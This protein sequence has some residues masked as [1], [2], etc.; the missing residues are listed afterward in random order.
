MRYIAL[1][2]LLSASLFFVSCIPVKKSTD[3]A[4]PGL[5]L[6]FVAPGFEEVREEFIRNFTSRNEIGAS[7]CIYYKGEKVVDLWGGYKDKKTKEPWEENT[8]VKV[9]ST[10]KGMALIVLAKLHSE[11]LLDYNEKVCTYWPEFA[12]NGKENITVEQLLTHK[13]GLVLLKRKVRV[14]ELHDF[15][16]M[17]VLLENA[18][19]S[20]EPGAKSGYHSAT[21]GLYIQ[22][23]VMRID[24]EGDNYNNRD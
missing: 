23:L 10:T 15:A 8:I 11:G 18:A 20:W 7:C 14:T 17:S 21:I 9:F 24:K 2:I 12:R 3:I 16:T 13:A 22:Q 6:C 5:D 4:I 19:P 1:I